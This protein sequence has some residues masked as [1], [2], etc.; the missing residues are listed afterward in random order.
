MMVSDYQDGTHPRFVPEATGPLTIFKR[1]V[2]DDR[3]DRYFVGADPSMTISGD[4]ACIQVINRS[5]MEQ[6]AVWHGRIDPINFAKEMMLIGRYYN[7]AMLCPEVEGGGQATI[8]CILTSGYPN[9]WQHRWA[10]KA[11][12]KVSI[13][14]GWATNWQRK[15]WC[16]GKLKSLIADGSVSVHDSKTYKQLRNYVVLPNG[17]MG[18]AD[19][20]IHDDA[21]MAMAI[22]VTASMTE[23]PYIQDQPT[24]DIFDMF[25]D[26]EVA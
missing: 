10:D 8:A 4:P 12:G 15:Q 22:C 1:P 20:T 11:P 24:D 13:S 23:G 21:V 19:R 26:I 17:D 16:I 9:I 18:N 6:V 3:T 7:D 2:S 25:N 5:T 14:Y